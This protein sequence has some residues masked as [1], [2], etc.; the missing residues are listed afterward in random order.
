MMDD[1]EYVG[2]NSSYIF[3]KLEKHLEP[4]AYIAEFRMDS[5][6]KHAHPKKKP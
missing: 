5:E 3:H 6:A 1:G 4:H 2:K